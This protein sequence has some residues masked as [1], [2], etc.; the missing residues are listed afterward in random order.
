[1]GVII[2]NGITYGGSS[3]ASG[4]GDSSQ[5][6]I[7]PVPSS[8]MV[9]RIVQYVGPSTLSYTCGYFYKCVENQTTTPS[10]YFWIEQ[11][12]QP[13]LTTAQKNALIALLEV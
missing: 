13:G 10:S 1:M 2:K 3:S 4:G 11:D 8:I 6:N 12:V 7:M 9:N 5:V